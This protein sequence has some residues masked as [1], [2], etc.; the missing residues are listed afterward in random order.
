[1]FPIAGATLVWP[2]IALSQ[3]ASRIIVSGE[4]VCGA[5]T[6]ERKF[7]QKHMKLLFFFPSFLGYE[8]CLSN[9][10]NNMAVR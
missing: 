8:Q 7:H 9:F 3:E 1:M 4:C 6:A 5:V 10:S 2:Y